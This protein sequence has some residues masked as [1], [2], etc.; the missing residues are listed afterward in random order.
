MFQK[1]IV[2]GCLF[3]SFHLH[4]QSQ[5][6][7][8]VVSDSIQPVAGESNLS[9]SQLDSIMYTS[10]HQFKDGFYYSRNDFMHNRPITIDKVMS[11][12]PMTDPDFYA[13][14]LQAGSF[15]VIIEDGTYKFVNVDD[16]FGFVQNRIL[17]LNMGPYGF[18]RI[19]N[20]GSICY[21]TV[22]QDAPKVRPSVGVGMS[23]WGGAGVGLGV[24]IGGGATV[25]EFIF[26][27]QGGP[28][29]ELSPEMLLE[30]IKDDEIIFNN[31][32]AL[33]KRYKLKEMHATL[34]EYNRRNPLYLPK[35]N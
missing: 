18:V 22:G 26:K 24:S 21:V 32:V 12:V 13:R 1:K 35:S 14:V 8:D 33:N 16:I 17:Y 30:M 11:T 15:E 29:V 9:E 19:S 23:S 34:H 20:I 3:L 31:Y 5:H 28:M 4:V 7:N 25:T 6:L 10:T 27:L 2:L